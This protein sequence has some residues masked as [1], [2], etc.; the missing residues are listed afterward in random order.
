MASVAVK[1]GLPM[2]SAGGRM[3]PGLIGASASRETVPRAEEEKE[4]ESLSG[5]DSTACMPEPWGPD[6]H[7]KA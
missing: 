3:L 1:M 7:S 6:C 4:K 5:G 2:S